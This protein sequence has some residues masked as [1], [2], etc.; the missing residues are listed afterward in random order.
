MTRKVQ[1]QLLGEEL[2]GLAFQPYPGDLGKRIYE[3]ISQ[4]GWQ[5]WLAHQ[6]M[7]INENRLSPINPEHRKFLETEMEKFFFGEGS[8]APEGYVPPDE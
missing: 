5:R 3:N 1:C 4:Q 7:L 8:E 2:E 6:T